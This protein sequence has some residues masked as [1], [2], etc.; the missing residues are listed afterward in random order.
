MYALYARLGDEVKIDDAAFDAARNQMYL[1]YYLGYTNTLLPDSALR[2]SLMFDN[3]MQYIYDHANVQ[4]E[5]DGA[6]P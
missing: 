3:V 6:T 1:Y 5:S 4:W 2:E